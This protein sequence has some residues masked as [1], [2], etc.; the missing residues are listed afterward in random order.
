MA[1]HIF[2]YG[3]LLGYKM[4]LLDIGGGFPGYDDAKFA[5]VFNKIFNF[6]SKNIKTFNSCRLL[7]LL[8]MPLTAIFPIII[9]IL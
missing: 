5:A 4:Y 2:D 7:K 6:K 8:T 3:N 1:K 9:S